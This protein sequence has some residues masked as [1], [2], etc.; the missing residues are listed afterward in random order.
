MAELPAKKP[1]KYRLFDHGSIA[2]L[3]IVEALK[4]TWPKNQ[5]IKENEK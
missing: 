1:L 2:S 4:K 5:K 3:M